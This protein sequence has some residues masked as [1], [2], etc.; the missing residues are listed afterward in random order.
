MHNR[1]IAVYQMFMGA[2][3]LTLANFIFIE[4]PF[5][6][7]T[8]GFII[9]IVLIVF[10]NLIQIEKIE[11]IENLLNQEVKEEKKKN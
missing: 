6:D 5:I 4:N 1:E 3:L 8:I 10:F 11:G 7:R 9:T 2:L